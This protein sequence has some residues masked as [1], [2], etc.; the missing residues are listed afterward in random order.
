M[1]VPS[2]TK[3]LDGILAIASI[4]VGSPFSTLVAPDG[5]ANVIS[6][7][8]NGVVTYVDPAAGGTYIQALVSPDGKVAS[9]MPLR[10]GGPMPHARW[11]HFA[12]II[13]PTD[14]L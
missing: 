3:D 10:S 13:V 12:L 2:F 7:D 9:F 11:W 6:V 4:S 5:S 14:G 8:P 1:I